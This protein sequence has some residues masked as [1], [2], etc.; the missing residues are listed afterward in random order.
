VHI[1]ANLSA[2]LRPHAKSGGRVTPTNYEKLLKQARDAAGIVEWPQNGLR[3]S[4]ASYHLAQFRRAEDLA[5][6]MGHRGTDILFRHY[7][8][9]VKPDA[10]NRYWEIMPDG[11]S[12]KVVKFPKA[13]AAA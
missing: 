13:A 10:A 6:E 2:W 12:A 7:R 11:H 8:E 9:L 3:H 1:L 5:E 4:Y